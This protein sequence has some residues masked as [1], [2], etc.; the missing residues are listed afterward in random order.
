[1]EIVKISKTNA[2]YGFFVYFINKKHVSR[3]TKTKFNKK[4]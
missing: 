4:S 3:L 1:M 2:K